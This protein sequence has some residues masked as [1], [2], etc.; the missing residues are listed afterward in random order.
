VR[1]WVSGIFVTVAEEI[2]D[3]AILILERCPFRKAVLPRATTKKPGHIANHDPFGRV[4]RDN[5]A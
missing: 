4:S 2:P 5:G 1:E 3:L